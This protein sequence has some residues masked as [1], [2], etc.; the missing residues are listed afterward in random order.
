MPSKRKKFLRLIIS[1]MV[2]TP[3]ILVM[4]SAFFLNYTPFFSHK[5]LIEKSVQI[6]G[7]YMISAII[8]LIYNRRYWMFLAF[9]CCAALC[10][11]LKTTSNEKFDYEEKTNDLAITIANFNVSHTQDSVQTIINSIKNCKA[12]LLSI[13]ELSPSLDTI[14]QQSL[15]S[16]YPNIY[17]YSSPDNNG[18]MIC[19][20]YPLGRTDTFTY[21]GLPN[22]L[23]CINIEKENCKLHFIS[24]Y[25][26]PPY[27]LERY[28]ELRSH[29]GTIAYKAK[30]I[31]AP[32][33]AIGTF[34]TVPWAPEI[35]DFKQNGALEDSRLGFEP[36]YPNSV[37][38]MLQV[39]YDHIFHSK[40][41]KCVGFGAINASGT[42][43]MGIKG[44]FQFVKQ[45]YNEIP[46]K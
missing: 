26:L 18:M 9:G 30:E 13:Q 44:T 28:K 4:F 8:L 35:Q 36:T 32:L 27:N 25:L 39:P 45:K 31:D 42:D 20:K 5:L 34:N 46:K 41:L 29:L 1:L 24:C 33:V 15:K 3:A 22:I 7:I 43:H 12:D 11:F 40:Y 14:F 37:P 6:V 17:S 10:M 16:T 21:H 38:S 2:C 19:S 23:G